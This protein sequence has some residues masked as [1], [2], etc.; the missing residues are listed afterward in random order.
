MQIVALLGL[1]NLD[2][3]AIVQKNKAMNRISTLCQYTTL[4]VRRVQ[5]AAG[6]CDAVTDNSEIHLGAYALSVN[7]RLR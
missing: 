3:T 5:R 7:G 4:H 1:T 2:D 6:R